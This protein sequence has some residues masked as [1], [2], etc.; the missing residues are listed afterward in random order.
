MYVSVYSAY[1]GHNGGYG[2]AGL[3]LGPRYG[4]G[5][6]KGPN[7]GRNI[8]MSNKIKIIMRLCL[9]YMNNYNNKEL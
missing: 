3:S 8:F 9:E 6:M 4:N 2:S 5:G 7:K 1:I